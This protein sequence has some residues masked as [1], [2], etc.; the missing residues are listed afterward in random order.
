MSLKLR[1]SLL[2]TLLAGS[3]LFLF[4]SLIYFSAAN[5]RRNEF[6][7]LLQK[8]ALTR[9]NLLLGAKVDAE[10]LQTIYL[11]NREILNEV[12]VPI[13]DPDFNLLYHDAVEIDFVKETPEMIDEILERGEIRFVQERWEVIGMVFKHNSNTYVLTA[14]AFD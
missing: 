4:A 2:F 1:F 7:N 3:I 12:E 8:E 5:D 9:A 11:S 6:F 13:Y 14:A 10:I